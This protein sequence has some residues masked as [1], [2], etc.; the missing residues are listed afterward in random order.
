MFP[1][2]FLTVS[3]IVC[4]RGV[5]AV[6]GGRCAQKHAAHSPSVFPCD[7]LV[8][9]LLRLEHNKRKTVVRIRKIHIRRYSHALDFSTVSEALLQL[10]MSQLFGDVLDPH[11]P[12]VDVFLNC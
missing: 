7:S 9:A 5:A 2:S 12:G 4:A 6:G 1:V 10:F 3:L 11:C 8:G